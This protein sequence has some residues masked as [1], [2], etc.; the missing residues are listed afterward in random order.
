MK[1]SIFSLAIIALAC[2]SCSTKNDTFSIAKDSIGALTPT[3]LV[4]A[5]ETTFANDSIVKFVPGGEF[6]ASVNEIEIFEKVAESSR[7]D[8]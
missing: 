3:T 8:A 6:T 4:K 1:K 7:Q 2:V 5:L